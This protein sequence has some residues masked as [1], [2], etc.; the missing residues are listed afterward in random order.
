MISLGRRRILSAFLAAF[1]ILTVWRARELS[2]SGGGAAPERP[3]TGYSTY[4]PE[5]DYFWRTI[6]HNFPI[7]P[8]QM[9]SMPT[10]AAATLPP[11][12]A[13][14]PP[15]TADE[16]KVRLGRQNDIKESFVK[17]WN[18]YKKYAWLRDEVTP[19]SGSYKD[20]FGGWGATLIDALDTLWIM[21]LKDEFEYAV[22]DVEKNALFLSTLSKEINVFETTIRFLGGLLS[23]YDLS[24]DKRLLVKAH[25][26]GD[27]LYK[28]FDTPNHL[29]I[30]RWDLHEAAHGNKQESQSSSLLAE[31]GS[32]SLE[33]T[34]LS[35]LTGDPKYY[36]AVQHISE[37]LAASQKKTKLPGMWPVVV[38]TQK[39]YFD[40]GTTYT[41]GGMA[42][43]TYEYF[44]KM[45]ALLGQQD[46]IYYDMYTRSM[47]A[48]NEHLFF[49]PMTPTSED[50]LFPGFVDIDVDDPSRKKELRPASG[51]L[52]CFTG[53]MLAF[54]GKL[55]SSN[56]HLAWAD[57]LTNGCVWAYRSF[58]TGVMPE[59]FYLTP[60]ADRD[61]CPWD[62][63]KWQADVAKA[64]GAGGGAKEAQSIIAKEHIPEGFS[65]IMDARYIL[66]P[67][68]IESVFI[69]YRITGDRRWQD[70]AWEMWKAIDNL[71]STKLANSAVDNMNPPD[72]QKVEMADS[73]ESF[74]LGE[75]LKYFYLIF[76]EP[77]LISLDEWVFNTEAH[78]FKRL[79]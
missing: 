36:D 2:A 29:P 19:V 65:S 20:P 1:V 56:D 10:S 66:R 16:K 8:S 15:E 70:K 14:F 38:D 28:A 61:S 34:R 31:I 51:H 72:G 37:L 39:E 6:K 24:G 69:M 26:V 76:S 78:P 71:T 11:V 23:A 9:R 33:F 73:M 21:G 32:L 42:D 45:M 47:E 30:A 7:A 52:T 18:A 54:G 40:A 49:R 60:C 62:A 12:Q 4:E 17:S 25:N 43:S 68:A 77:D 58:T 75:T 35:L 79:R 5:K 74:W 27:M 57:K 64:H 48:A 63:T 3:M 59:T 46:G 13:K 50:I 55:I 41:L 53:G 67:E 22:Y 44:P